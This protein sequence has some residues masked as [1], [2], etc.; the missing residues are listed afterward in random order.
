MEEL[1][2]PHYSDHDL[3]IRLDTKLLDV[4]RDVREVKDN[5]Q[6]AI[7]ALQQKVIGYD[8]IFIEY[9]PKRINEMTLAHEKWISDFKLTYR[10]IIGMAIGISSIITFILTSLGYVLNLLGFFHQK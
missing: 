4:S 7:S 8:Q 5:T 9:P 10:L 1:A 6:S 2:S 3:L